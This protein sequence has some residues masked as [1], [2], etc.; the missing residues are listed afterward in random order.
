MKFER[1]RLSKQKVPFQSSMSYASMLSKPAPV[2]SKDPILQSSGAGGLVDEIEQ[3]VSLL[4]EVKSAPENLS[5]CVEI[6]RREME[7]VPSAQAPNFRTGVRNFNTNGGGGGGNGWR[8][9]TKQAPQ[10]SVFET[11]GIPKNNSFQSVKSSESA[12]SPIASTPKPSL[13]YQSKFKSQDNLQ[14]KILNTIIGNKLNAFT[15]LTYKDTRDFIYQILDSGETEFCRDFVEKVFTKATLE[16]LYCGLFAKLI[17][18]IAKTYPVMYEEMNK[19]HKDF[20]KIF[21]TVQEDED[22]ELE[23]TIKERQYRMGYGTFLAELA[24]QNALQK[25]ELLSMV[26]KVK[27]K[28]QEFVDTPGKP[29]TVNEFV[30][31]LVRLSENLKQR[32]PAFFAGVRGD[33]WSVLEDCV[34]PLSVKG[35]VRPSLSAKA[36]FA[37][38]DLQDLLTK[39]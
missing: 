30:D 24:G 32:C 2:P 16:D 5:R 33:M 19:Y 18:E 35:V 12:P 38:M 25:E 22:A 31:C 13:R 4:S 10:K 9:G 26:L 39:N 11:R 36:R 15:P 6:L 20:L 7:A 17:A 37:L 1:M 27:V 28:I 3:W 29:K 14:G 34:K 21:E 8:S 23:A